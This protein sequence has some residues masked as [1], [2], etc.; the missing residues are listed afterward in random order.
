LTRR[1][2]GALV[3]LVLAAGPALA[4][5][6]ELLCEAQ[7]RAASAPAAPASHHGASCHES[8]PESDGPGLSATTGACAFHRD[9]AADVAVLSAS[10]ADA[11][12]GVAPAASP[13]VPM[14]TVVGRHV[15]RAWVGS[16]PGPPRD[17]LRSVVLRI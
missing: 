16:P 11:D 14:A 3:L 6:C 9:G 15:V 2:V 17:A 10:R 13:L 1:I 4:T 12:L 8:A 5:T 7:A